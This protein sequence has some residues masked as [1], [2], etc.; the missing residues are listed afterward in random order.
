MTE[1][2][3]ACGCGEAIIIKRHHRWKG[4]PDYSQ[5]HSSRVNNPMQGIYPSK[6]TRKKMSDSRKGIVHSIE[7]NKKISETQ[8]G[9]H[10]TPGNDFK[11]GNTI[12]I[13]R[14]HSA[15]AKKK[16]SDAAIGRINS[17][18]TRKKISESNIGKVASPEHRRKVSEALSGRIFSPGHCKKI[19]FAKKENYKD[20][21]FCKKMGKAWGIKP[22]KPETLMLNL[23]EKFYPGEWKYTGDFSF[24]INGKSPDFTNCNGQKRLIEVFGDYWHCGENPQD[25]IDSFKLFGFETLVVWERELKDIKKLKPVLDAF[26]RGL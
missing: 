14:H 21:E 3:C 13:G 19:S 10:H 23:L 25:R 1:K 11:K 15:E 17:P 18:E 5:G 24:T 7:R 9:R 6:E 16:M 22:N 20:P 8:K 26:C 2:L 4:V 12:N